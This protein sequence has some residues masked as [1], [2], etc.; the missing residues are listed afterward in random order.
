MVAI[1]AAGSAGVSLTNVIQLLSSIKQAQEIGQVGQTKVDRC[2]EDMTNILKNP[3]AANPIQVASAVDALLDAVSADSSDPSVLRNLY[4]QLSEIL[5]VTNSQASSGKIQDSGSISASDTKPSGAKASQTTTDKATAKWATEK[6]NQLLTGGIESLGELALILDTLDVASGLISA[7][8]LNKIKDSLVDFVT[9]ISA[10]CTSQ[11]ELNGVLQSIQASVRTDNPLFD[12][13]SGLSQNQDVVAAIG[14]NPEAGTVGDVLTQNAVAG[15]QKSIGAAASSVL[16]SSQ[17]EAG[18]EPA[19][20]ID[21]A[22]VSAFTTKVL[23][24]ASQYVSFSSENVSAIAKVSSIAA[25]TVQQIG[26]KNNATI[27]SLLTEHTDAHA[28][29]SAPNS[30][31]SDA[32]QSL[33]DINHA[34]LLGQ[35]LSKGKPA[36]PEAPKTLRLESLQAMSAKI[37][38]SLASGPQGTPTPT[39]PTKEPTSVQVAMAAVMRE[40]KFLKVQ[41]SESGGMADLTKKPKDLKR[42][43]SDAFSKDPRGV[44]D[45]LYGMLFGI[46]FTRLEDLMQEIAL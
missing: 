43:L 37:L 42:T 26:N 33:K 4:S 17:T 32:V 28:V 20:L 19:A 6:I 5:N 31:R 7:D 38:K 29:S 8:I 45:T 14:S 10:G 44:A 34:E 12:F 21:T 35:Q 23:D 2:L 16:L 24:H 27:N 39:Q 9:K 41:G 22:T 30:L 11:E 40:K 13:I 15:I 1:Q 3:E 25:E 46:A 36:T 18:A